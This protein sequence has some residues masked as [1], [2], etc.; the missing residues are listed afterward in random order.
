MRAQI[1]RSCEKPD[2]VRQ[3]AETFG[4]NRLH[5]DALHEIGGRQSAAAPRPTRG[6]QNVVAATGVIAERLCGPWP[7]K[8]RSSG[9]NSL[10]WRSFLSS[11]LRKAE[12]FR[13]KAIH[14]PIRCIGG[15]RY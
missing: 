8:D 3:A 13:R 4:A 12:M 6:G 5:A 11:V 2:I 15:R 9:G 7:Y 1:F 14:K 10:E